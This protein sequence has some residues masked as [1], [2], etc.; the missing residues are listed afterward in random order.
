MSQLTH[1]LPRRDPRLWGL[2]APL[3]G[4][5]LAAAFG[6]ALV[7]HQTLAMLP[8][9]L[10]VVLPLVLSQRTRVLF[11]V[12]GALLVFQSSDELNLRKML[13]LFGVMVAFG[14]TLY[15]LPTLSRTRAFHLIAPM[16]RASVAIFVMLA[17]SGIVA[18]TFDV[19]K[20]TWLRDIGPY[21]LF[22]F[23]PFFAL[24]AA[25]SFSGTALR[26]LLVVAGSVSGLS[27]MLRWLANRGLADLGLAQIGLPT[28]LLAASAFAFGL[29]VVLEG[30][31]RRLA[32]LV[33]TIVLFVMLVS[34]GTRTIGV[35]L[36]A[37]LAIVL[38]SRRH[39]ARRSL[40]LVVALPIAV[41]I[42]VVAFL[43][44]VNFGNVE[45]AE[46][47]RRAALLTESLGDT[48]SDQSYL[49]RADQTRTSWSLFRSSPLVGVGPGHPFPWVNYRG[50]PQPPKTVVDSPISYFAKF[51][52]M[53]AVTLVIL[54]LGFISLLRRLAA[55]T[56]GRSVAQ[57]ALIGYAAIVAATF[58][59]LVPFED[60]GLSTAALLL[61]AVALR[62]AVDAQKRRGAA[63]PS[64][65]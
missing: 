18:T 24:E 25:A 34:T 56:G 32:W 43:T 48:G 27:F 29:A 31:R 54:A 28:L 21:A 52:I 51:G 19:P 9:A 64:P 36:A 14:G 6:W 61:L 1:R 63:A 7:R 30:E 58:V 3:A 20:Q 4:A 42:G 59:L 53:G 38:G 57:L 47:S 26:R 40:R 11:V 62:E 35:L 49:D 46:L 23:A 41:V 60:K 45:R 50:I 5:A 33:L 22:A 16:L 10:I 39:L 44:V 2:A 17:A 8:V 65:T 37:P 13:Y 15:N 12:F 55:A